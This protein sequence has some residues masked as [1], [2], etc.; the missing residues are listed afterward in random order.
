MTYSQIRKNIYSPT[1]SLNLIAKGRMS[2]K[3][4][5]VLA[6]LLAKKMHLLGQSH[7]NKKFW[8]EL[9]A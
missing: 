4:T 1:V 8:E 5:A 2:I 9:I 7:K 6:V 3:H